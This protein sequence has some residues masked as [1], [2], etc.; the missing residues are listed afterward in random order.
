[1]S[2]LTKFDWVKVFNPAPKDI[3]IEHVNHICKNCGDSY[4]GEFCNYCGQKTIEFNHN[5]IID[6]FFEGLESKRGLLFNLKV[7]TFTPAK[8]MKDY[9]E[10]RT[11]PYLNPIS[12]SIFV[13]TILF[14]TGTKVNEHFGFNGLTAEM[15]YF[16]HYLVFTFP[17]MYALGSYLSY[18]SKGYNY[19]QHFILSMMLSS[20]YILLFVIPNMYLGLNW[21][22]LL[23][24]FLVYTIWVY[25]LLFK[26]Q[27]VLTIVNQFT[28][29]LMALFFE[30]FFVA[31]TFIL[32]YYFFND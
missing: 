22:Y 12:Y 24:G 8:A 7:L 23:I 21:F 30:S 2:L 19:I 9:M 14:L 6:N 11:K 13:L 5:Y 17:V 18:T 32:P 25:Q 15:P 20:H 3:K 26:E 4:K 16:L 27:M 10:G 28:T 31:L 29:L 1:M